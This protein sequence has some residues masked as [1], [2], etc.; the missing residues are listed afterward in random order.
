MACVVALGL[1]SFIAL[2]A[3]AGQACGETKATAHSRGGCCSRSRVVMIGCADKCTKGAGACIGTCC[4]LE[5][6]LPVTRAKRAAIVDSINGTPAEK[7]TEKTEQ[8]ASF[9]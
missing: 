7:K 4:P 8:T 9:Y 1:V 6:E 5:A 2:S 3:W